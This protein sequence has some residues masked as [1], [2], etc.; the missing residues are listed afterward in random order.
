MIVKNPRQ[1]IDYLHD[2]ILTRCFEI[3]HIRW[4]NKHGCKGIVDEC[5]EDLQAEIDEIREEI[6]ELEEAIKAGKEIVK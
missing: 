4:A 6:E 3:E 1:R 2:E 5:E